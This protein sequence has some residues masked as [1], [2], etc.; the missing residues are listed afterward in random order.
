MKQILLLAF[1]CVALNSCSSVGYIAGGKQTRFEGSYNL[2]IIESI[3]NSKAKLTSILIDEGWNKA[4]ENDTMIAFENTASKG[5]QVGIGKF[6][7]ASIQAIF[8]SEKATL[9]IAQFGNFKYG[10]EEAV[11]KTFEKIK[12]QYELNQN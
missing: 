11:N 12:E 3:K 9:T 7:M 10:T 1:I 8:D 5:S 2:P 4:R 6:K